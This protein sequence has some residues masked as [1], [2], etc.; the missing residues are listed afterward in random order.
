MNSFRKNTLAFFM[1]FMMI[2]S[3][4]PISHAQDNMTSSITH[5]GNQVMIT[6]N[7]TPDTIVTLL[8]LRVED[9]SKSY[10]NETKSNDQGAYEFSFPLKGGEYEVIVTSN[11]IHKQEKLQIL[12]EN[13]AVATVR[14]EGATKTL[15]PLTEVIIYEGETTLL[16]AVKKGLEKQNVDYKMDGD[17]I[18]SIS[19]EVGWQW[20]LN[21]KGGMAIPSTKLH[22]G[23]QIIL[24]DDEIWDPVIT[25]LKLSKEEV[26][27]GEEFTVYLKI[28]TNGEVPVSNQPIVYGGVEKKTD[29]EGKAIFTGS[30]TGKVEAPLKGKWIRPVPLTVQ[31]HSSS[32]NKPGQDDKSIK[33]DM[34]IEGYK[35]TIF[36]DK[37]SFKLK[38]YRGSDGKYRI[39]DP[40]GEEHVFDRPTVF[41]ATVV[42]WNQAGISDNIVNSKD[43]GYYIA[44]M[45]GEQEFDFKD[46]HPTCGWMIRVNDVVIPKGSGAWEIKDKDKVE[47]YYTSIDPGVCFG[48]IDVSPTNLKTGEKLYVKVNGKINNFGGA[49][50]SQPIEGAIVY[51]G[52]ETYTTDKEGK[53]E[54][55]M[56]TA[57]TFDVYAIKL[58]KNSKHGQ[59]YFPLV[60]RTEK[61]KVTVTGKNISG[62]GTISNPDYQKEYD[63]IN[64]PNTNEKDTVKATKDAIDKFSKKADKVQNEKDAQNMIKDGKDIG[65]IIEKAIEKVKTEEGAKDVFK[66]NIKVVNGL[67][68]SGEKLS[69]ENDKKEL[70]QVVA[71]NMN[72]TIKLV[73]VINDSK[74]VIK[75]AGECMDASGKVI[76]AIGKENSKEVIEKT[77]KLAQNTVEKVSMKKVT[78]ERITVEKEKAVVKVEEAMIQEASKNTASTVKIIN[79][80]LKSNG[81]EGI[82]LENKVIIQIPKV[83]QKEVEAVLSANIMK[84]V[85][86]NKVEKVSIQTE[87]A[88]FNVTPNTLVQKEIALSAKTIDRNDLTALEKNKVPKGCV[89]VDLNAKVE[90]EKINQFNEPMKVSL[91]YNGEVKTG[92]TVQVFYLKDNGTIENM[93]GIYDP[94]TKMVTFE[95]THFSK[96]FAQKVGKE[97]AKVTFSDLNGYEWATK[98]I[99]EMANKGIISGR[100]E[101]VFDPGASITRAEFATLITKMLGLNI[102]NI[103]VGFTDVED[104]AW[105]TPYIKTAY[106]NG[107]VSGRSETIFDPNGKITREEMATIIGKVLTQKGKE[108][109][110]TNELER[111]SD[112]TNIASWANENVALCVKEAII[113]GMPDGTFMP[114]ENA[115]RAQ[116]AMMLYNLYKS[117]Q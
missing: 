40:K 104:M 82:S 106:K 60:S 93:G 16:D 32:S 91:P 21:G 76:K 35:G 55:T 29:K 114:K 107:L 102:E 90:G 108:K 13:T 4:I 7:T 31:V 89:V 73:S 8:V 96:Y 27:S 100:S 67:A 41:L 51:V 42:A 50:S 80:K 14:V 38:D 17:M 63:I 75:L 72:H 115:N 61:V 45:A 65:K 39:T 54:I 56:N 25:K 30:T 111:F 83:E 6:G 112:K 78:K 117:I 85:K 52:N 94:N 47:W 81:I 23:D 101:D 57:G 92:E 3:C 70:S 59:Y 105:Y 69:K 77:I 53:A 28:D 110:N 74:E 46:E 86:E 36:D 5:E 116:A 58:D 43:K 22:A 12:D 62:G 99:E 97:E 66:E 2:F 34:R 15:L 68:K 49:G 84:I 79:E 95:A 64:N 1:I 9:Q 33:V 98:A 20:M 109:A 11:G 103:N 44:R 10:S 37:I 88:V 24:V 18:H 113:S 87:N 48:Y 26:N 71:Q 19:G